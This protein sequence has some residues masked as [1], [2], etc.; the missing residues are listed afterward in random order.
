MQVMD[1]VLYELAM[2]VKHGGIKFCLRV[3]EILAK[4]ARGAKVQK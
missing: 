2:L 1:D 4:N 3:M